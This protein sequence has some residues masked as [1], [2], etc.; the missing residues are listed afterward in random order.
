MVLH[1]ARI[2][3][4]VIGCW[5]ADTAAGFLHYYCKDEAVVNECGGGDELNGF[6]HVYD[7]LVGVE[8]DLELVTGLFHVPNAV[9]EPS[10]ALLETIFL[11]EVVS[12]TH[13]SMNDIHL[14]FEGHPSS[15]E[16]LP[17]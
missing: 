2:G 17:L 4:S 10:S 14:S 13:R 7:F 1:E 11:K 9:I 8:V 12:N 15:V 3:D 5:S 16:P 6:V